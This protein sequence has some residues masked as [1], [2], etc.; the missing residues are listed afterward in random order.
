MKTIKLIGIL[1]ILLALSVVAYL[2]VPKMI[3]ESE[4]SK[5]IGNASL[6]LLNWAKNNESCFNGAPGSGDCLSF[7][8]SYVSDYDSN[9]RIYE[10]KLME[11]AAHGLISYD[12]DGDIINPINGESMADQI[13]KIAYNQSTNTF[14]TVSDNMGE[15]RTTTT[16]T[17][18]R[19][20]TTTTKHTNADDDTTQYRVGRPSESNVD[21]SKLSRIHFID[22]NGGSDAI[23]IESNGHF[24]LVDSSNPYGST[25]SDKYAKPANQSIRIVLDYLKKIGVSH[26]DF[27][28]A[29][30]SHSDH[31]GGMVELASSIYVNNKTT[32]YYKPYITT[33][34]DTTTDYNN[35]GYYTKAYNAMKK[36]GV[37]LSDVTNKKVGFDLGNF[38]I[39]LYNTEK[40]TG[41]DR[42]NRNSIVEYITYKGKYKT[43]LLGDFER[44][45]EMVLANKY[46]HVVLLKI[47]HHGLKS[48]TGF[49][50]VDKLYPEN[51]VITNS[52]IPETFLPVGYYMQQRY[53]T[54]TYLSGSASGAVI[55]NYTDSGYSISDNGSAQTFT[56]A[57]TTRDWKYIQNGS[58]YAWTVY[59]SG[60]PVYSNWYKD[61]TGDW[62]YLNEAGIYVTGWNEL[63][64]E[65]NTNW[66]YFS[67]SGKMATGWQ[68]INNYYYYFGT[69]GKM[70]TSWQ[71][72]NGSW[73]YFNNNGRMVT[74]WQRLNWQGSTNTYYFLSS[75]KMATGYQQINGNYYYF[76]S[77]GS[78]ASNTCLRID[79]V[80]RCF[81]TDGEC[82]SGC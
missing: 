75:G 23:L 43:L 8:K 53:N 18:K 79:N 61:S 68:K 62:Y 19:T 30:H 20:T 65:G 49:D 25:S 59:K 16:T 32:Y 72:I 39:E 6:Q 81:N 41:L 38:H 11:I 1:I 15:L 66:Y 60:K 57:K 35:S 58:K 78:M 54:K 70:V 69:S 64:W 27:V 26:L 52:S 82:I 22:T 31:I 9:Q 63:K 74:G 76:Y 14:I 55:A 44:P 46:G 50:F 2:F 48:A 3:R 56:V 21:T 7:E 34:E 67:D 24:G 10:F 77:G 13:V 17:T 5:K 45:E 73:Y 33:K 47:G 71:Q 36:A 42:E 80:K 37:I 28:I 29:T 51:I 4:Y 40:K 12:K